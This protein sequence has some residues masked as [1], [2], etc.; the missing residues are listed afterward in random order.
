MSR[1]SFFPVAG[2]AFSAGLLAVVVVFAGVYTFLPGVVGGVVA[3][4]VQDWLNLQRPPEVRLR[5]DPP[6]AMLLGEFS[7]GRVVMEGAEFGGL[8]TRRV[9]VM[10]EP[11][12]VRVLRSLREGELVPEGP[13]SGDL[14]VVVS[15]EEIS[16]VARLDSRV[17]RVDVRPGGVF[18]GSDVDILGN[19]LP[20][21]VRGGLSVR[22]GRLVFTP[23]SVY[24]AGAPLPRRVSSRMLEGVRFVYRLEGFP[25]GTEITGVRTLDGRILLTGRIEGILG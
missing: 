7:G 8:R 20:F 4:S 2:A 19:E 12:E 6:P 15:E 22:E 23:G 5:S 24:I 13:I 21:A 16:R 25:E 11:F 3:R 18:V 17:S 10:L 14:R 1:G 9:E